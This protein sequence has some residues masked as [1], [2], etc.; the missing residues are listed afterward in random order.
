MNR[1]VSREDLEF[2]HYNILHE[3]VFRHKETGDIYEE[4]GTGWIKA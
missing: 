2:S 3:P 4:G 1:K